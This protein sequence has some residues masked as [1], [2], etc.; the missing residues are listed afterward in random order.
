MAKGFAFYSFG[1]FGTLSMTIS[2]I[3]LMTNALNSDNSNL[4]NVNK[5]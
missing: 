2:M 3:L 4:Y 5:L 1:F